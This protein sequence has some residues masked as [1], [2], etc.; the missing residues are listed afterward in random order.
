MENIELEFESLSSRTRSVAERTQ[1]D[2]ELLQQL[3]LFLT[4]ISP[5]TLRVSV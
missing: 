4:V 2:A 1:T 3:D 5:R